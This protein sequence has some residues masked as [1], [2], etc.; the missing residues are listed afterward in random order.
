MDP[1]EFLPREAYGV[2]HGTAI[3]VFEREDTGV[4]LSPLALAY[5]DPEDDA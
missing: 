1:N 5:P 2:N 4:D 3:D